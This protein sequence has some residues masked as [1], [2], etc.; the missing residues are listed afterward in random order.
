LDNGFELANVEALAN[1]DTNSLHLRENW[2]VGNVRGMELEQFG[3]TGEI[4]PRCHRIDLRLWRCLHI[5]AWVRLKFDRLGRFSILGKKADLIT[6]LNFADC[7]VIWRA[8]RLGSADKPYV[9]R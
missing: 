2:L 5:D 7:V 1:F 8:V 9:R 6:G 3:R 4:Y